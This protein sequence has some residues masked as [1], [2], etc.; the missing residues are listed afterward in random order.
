MTD[1]II[2]PLRAITPSQAVSKLDLSIIEFLISFGFNHLTPEDFER[3]ILRMFE[4]FGYS[5]ELTPITGDQGIDIILKSADNILVVVQCKRYDT[6]QTISSR[7]IREFFGSMIHA[8]AKFGYFITT[9]SFSDQ[10]KSFC[11]GKNIELI[12]GAS[13]QSLFLQSIRAASQN[14]IRELLSDYVDDL[15]K[16]RAKGCNYFTCKEPVFSEHKGKLYCLKHYQALTDFEEMK[17]GSRKGLN[18]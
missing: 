12:D 4:G 7:E 3:L 5:G 10:A 16:E 1:E 17:K 6:E 15:E 11:A 13:L 14:I 9:S 8:D 2:N 18:L